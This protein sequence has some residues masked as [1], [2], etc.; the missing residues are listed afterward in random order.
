MA[1]FN[2]ISNQMLTGSSTALANTANEMKKLVKSFNEMMKEQVREDFVYKINSLKDE[3][4]TYGEENIH[5]KYFSTNLMRIF[6]DYDYRHKWEVFVQRNHP[7]NSGYNVANFYDENKRIFITE[8]KMVTYIKKLASEYGV[9]TCRYNGCK[10][11]IM[12]YNPYYD[13][14]YSI[15]FYRANSFADKV[16]WLWYD[17]ANEEYV[18]IDWSF[19]DENDKDRIFTDKEFADMV[20]EKVCNISEY[21]SECRAYDD[22][23]YIWLNRDITSIRKEKQENDWRDHIIGLFRSYYD[24]RSMADKEVNLIIDPEYTKSRY[25]PPYRP[26]DNYISYIGVERAMEIYNEM[27]E[28]YKN[29]EKVFAGEDSDGCIY[30][31]LVLEDE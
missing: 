3:I 23:F 17:N 16:C 6:Y 10:I 24:D 9:E 21:F 20:Y 8:K 1:H 27:K 14:E 29:A 13:K 2:E 4:A 26:Y 22:C 5:K 11:E 31:K 28:K 18:K 7:N 30:Y 25:C 19:F 12:M 15:M